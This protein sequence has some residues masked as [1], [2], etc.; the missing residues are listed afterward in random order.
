MAE[1]SLIYL[2][3]GEDG[4]KQ[5]VDDFLASGNSVD[6]L[7]ALATPELREPPQEEDDELPN[8][9]R[10]NQRGL[11]WEKSTKD[12]PVPVQL[13]NFTARIIGD[14]VEDDGAEQWRRFEIEA[15]LN[16]RRSVFAVPAERF[17]GMG[18]PTE[19]L[20][21]AAILAPGFGLKD[22]ARVAIQMVSGDIPRRHVY[23][24]TGWRNIGGE[25]VYLHAGGPIGPNGPLSGIEVSLGE[26]R[27]ADY[28]LPAPP[29]GDELVRAIRAS[30]RFLELAPLAIIVPLLAAIYRAPLGEA[31]AG[32]LSLALVGPT[33]TQKTELTAMAQAHYGAAFNGRRLPANWT[34]TENA[35][36]KQAFATKD[37]LLVV[38]DFA[39]A[40]TTY[41]VARLHRTADRLLRAQGNRS[42]RGRMRS[43]TTLRA[44][45]HPRGFIVSSGEDVPR[46]QSLRSRMLVLEVSPGDVDLGTLTEMQQAAAQGLLASSMSGYLLWLAQRMAGLKEGLPERHRELRTEAMGAGTH[47]RTPDAVASLGLGLRKFLDFATQSGAIT[48]ARAEGLWTEGWKALMEAAEAQAEH[49]SGEEPTQQ[50]LELLASAIVAGEAHVASSETGGEPQN[51]ERWGWRP[52]DFGTDEYEPAAV[53]PRGRRIGW[54]HKD[55]S[56]LLEPGAAF[57]AA[58]RMAREQG[59]GLSI[60]QRT[61]WKRMHEKGLLAS[62]DAARG[63]N[64][65]RATVAGERKTVVHLVAGVLSPENGPIG[66]NDPGPAGNG[67]S[68]PKLGAVSSPPPPQTARE[69][70]PEPAQDAPPGP[71]GTIGPFLERGS[72]EE[73]EEIDYL[74]T[75]RKLGWSRVQ[76]VFSAEDDPDGA[77]LDREPVARRLRHEVGI[78]KGRD[79]WSDVYGAPTPL[80]VSAE[81]VFGL[82]PEHG[83]DSRYT[84]WPATPEETAARLKRVIP[85]LTHGVH[86]F[87]DP[88]S[89]DWYAKAALNHPR[90]LEKVCKEARLRAELWRKEGTSEELWVLVALTGRWRV[91]DAVIERRV[92]VRVTTGRIATRDYEEVED[93]GPAYV[94]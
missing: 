69:N 72:A 4:S 14:V 26:G 2:P 27:L 89:S 21:A 34:S 37:A 29:S 40:G 60:G 84:P 88:G 22:H 67:P 51:A 20:G 6:D 8:P 66:P 71:K 36:E 24:H 74:A 91:P 19:Y 70:G 30:L 9:Y 45:Y 73:E 25:W 15:E 48:S 44:E 28:S 32:D 86:K 76:T 23:A 79:W 35:L 16:G 64:M 3:H 10:E 7:L 87:W 31:L 80:V 75:L 93:P 62:R 90:D 78:Y 52:R 33:G 83:G 61:L 53:Q 55:A 13:T 59:T 85:L 94:F 39:P 82:V 65:T 5:G 92:W 56:L 41:D 43:D 46:G 81:D 38:D 12:G 77:L 58:Q 17:S 49:Q 42:G 50:F 47:A 57:A 18:W 1:V 68:G 54:L 11:V 63:R